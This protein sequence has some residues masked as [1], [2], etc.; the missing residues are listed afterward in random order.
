M[1]N[2]WNAAVWIAWAGLAMWALGCGSHTGSSTSCGQCLSGFACENRASFYVDKGDGTVLD[3]RTGLTWQQSDDG[4]CYNWDGAKSYCA[5]LTLAGGDW[6]LPSRGELD[7]LSTG[8]APIDRSVFAGKA[9]PLSGA[10][11][12]YWTSYETSSTEAWEVYING[13]ENSDAK[14][15]L[16][17]ALCVRGEACTG[18][19]MIIGDN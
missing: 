15:T 13:S 6:R 3:N 18:A 2:G 12:A 9:C 5:G 1:K 17:S 7:S 19:A 11:Y 8:L 16:N 14:T 4:M 10:Y